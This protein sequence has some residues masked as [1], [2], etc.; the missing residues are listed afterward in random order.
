MY[1]AFV[2][3]PSIES[4]NSNL[5]K[6][7]REM[8]LKFQ[9]TKRR[10]STQPGETMWNGIREIPL[11]HLCYCFDVSTSFSLTRYHYKSKNIATSRPQH[12]PPTHL[13]VLDI[14][15][16]INPFHKLQPPQKTMKILL[17]LTSTLHPGIISCA[18]KSVQ[19]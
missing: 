16:D 18:E 5:L 14:Q 13:Q 19:H 17:W 1:F 9:I 10:I 6:F 15:Q 12:Q 7:K 8:Y 11:T 4:H 3:T 2:T